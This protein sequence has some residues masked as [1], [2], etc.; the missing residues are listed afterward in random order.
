MIVFDEQDLP[1]FDEVME[2]LRRYP[3]FEFL[4]M[5]RWMPK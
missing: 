2:V 5:C 3:D 4:N 1:A